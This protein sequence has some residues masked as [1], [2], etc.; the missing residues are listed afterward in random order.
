M[1]V[2]DTNFLILL[3]D[4]DSTQNTNRRADRVRHFIETLAKSKEEIMIPAPSL[5]ELVAGR[6]ERVEEISETVKNLKNFSVQEFDTVIAIQTGELISFA[7]SRIP[8]NNR[9]PGW[10]VAMKYDAMIAAMALVRGARALCTTDMGLTKY[11][12]GSSVKVI[13]VDDL[14]LPSEDTQSSLAI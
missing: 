3:I 4:P 10:R 9:L 14:P 12:E 13:D 11:L 5:A 1:I 7:H 6:A 2:V 8:S